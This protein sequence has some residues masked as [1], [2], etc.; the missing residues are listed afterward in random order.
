MEE[1]SNMN[2]TRVYA[3]VLLVLLLQI[4]LYSWISSL[5]A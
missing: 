5:F 1:E 3:L 4:A 2:W